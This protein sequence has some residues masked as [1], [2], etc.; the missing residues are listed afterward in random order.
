[1]GPQ[2]GELN[3]PRLIMALIFL[4]LSAAASAGCGSMPRIIV[5]NDPLSADEHVTLGV[6]YEKEGKLELAS[7][8][9]ERALKKDPLSF[10]ARFNLGNVRLAEKQYDVARKHYLK[11]LEV[12]PDDPR[13]VNNY[14]WAAILSGDGRE[15]A[16]GRMKSVLSDPLHRKPIFLDTLGVLLMEMSRYSEAGEAF[17]E[18]LARC[19]AGDLSCT[20][21]V[22]AEIHDHMRALAVRQ[23][24][25]SSFIP[26]AEPGPL[27]TT[28]TQG[29]NVPQVNRRS[30]TYI[31]GLNLQAGRLRS[32]V[33]G[34][35]TVIRVNDCILRCLG[36]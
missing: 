5:L 9:Y 20:E 36:P 23:K 1:M 22:R 18:A 4:V 25:A 14:A 27:P 6:S 24:N 13:A 21:D 19:D 3:S 17:I 31:E 11:A 16:L 12:R 10:P 32:H 26:S 28:H 30:G 34:L 33:T 35:M 2:A 7:R 8:E 29:V 15:D